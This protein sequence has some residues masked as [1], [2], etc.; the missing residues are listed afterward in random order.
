MDKCDE[1][2][3][4]HGSTIEQTSP[5]NFRSKLL[6]KPMKI[7]TFCAQCGVPAEDIEFKF[8]SCGNCNAD[9]SIESNLVKG[10]FTDEDA[11]KLLTAN[12]DN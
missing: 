2:D 6:E 10:Q 9:L 12:T 11:Y 8:E 7:I 1:H 3:F 5:G 4:K